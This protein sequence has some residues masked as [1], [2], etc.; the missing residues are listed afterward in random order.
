MLIDWFS[1]EKLLINLIEVR[2]YQFWNL[3]SR[4]DPRFIKILSDTMEIRST[5]SFM[6]SGNWSKKY[7]R[8]GWKFDTDAFHHINKL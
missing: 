2:V 7:F 5:R 1:L 3:F 4:W 6:A 8:A